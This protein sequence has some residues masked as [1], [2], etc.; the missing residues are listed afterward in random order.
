MFY[1]S[2]IEAGP[3]DPATLLAVLGTIPG[4]V[5]VGGRG[6]RFVVISTQPLAGLPPGARLKE[7]RLSP[8]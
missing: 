1:L 2:E 6:G 5:S 8:V 3:V 7:T 4:V